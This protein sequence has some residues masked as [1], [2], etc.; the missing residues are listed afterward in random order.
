MISLKRRRRSNVCVIF[1][2]LYFL[3]IVVVGLWSPL[4]WTSVLSCGDLTNILFRYWRTDTS[5]IVVQFS[6]PFIPSSHWLLVSSNPSL[7]S[8]SLCRETFS[9]S[10][11]RISSL[12]VLLF[13]QIW[14]KKHTFGKLLAFNGQIRHLPLFYVGLCND[15]EKVIQTF[16]SVCYIHSIDIHHQFCAITGK[17]VYNIN[18]DQSIQKENGHPKNHHIERRRPP[19]SDH[20]WWC[21]T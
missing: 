18:Q 8:L 9:K 3:W 13:S 7:S 10:F 16:K 4:C 2:H 5:S 12:S 15:S 17:F 20:V 6:S 11:T 21:N 1:H 14:R 19:K